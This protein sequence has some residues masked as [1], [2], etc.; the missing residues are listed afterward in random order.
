MTLRVRPFL[1]N[2]DYHWL[3]KV[4]GKPFETPLRFHT[5][6]KFA[7]DAHW[8]YN[9][10]Y[11]EE[12]ERGF[13]FR[14]DLYSPGVYVFDLKPG[15]WAVLYASADGSEAAESAPVAKRDPFLVRRADGRP[16]IV[17]GYPWFTEWGRDTMISLPGLLIAPGKLEPARQIIETWLES[18][19]QGIIPN[20]FPDAGEEPAYNTADATLWMFQAVRM[21]LAAGGDPG[22]VHDVFLP[23]GARDYRLA[24]ARHPARH[25]RGPAGSPAAR[26]RAGPA[27]DLD[28]REGRRPGDYTARRQAGGDQRAVAF[29]AVPD[30]GVGGRRMLGGILPRAA[31][32]SRTVTGTTSRECLYDV[33]TDHGPDA[34]LRPNQVIAVS[35]GDNLLGR[36]QQQQAVM[37]T[38]ERE[39]LTPVGLRTLERGDPEYQGRYEGG[40]AERD[41]A[42]HQGTVWP[43]LLGPFADAYLA[44]FGRTPQTLE[45][46]SGLLRK[47]EEEAAHGPC[48]GSIPEI[49]DGD[50]PHLPRGCPA[51]AW[52]VA[53]AARLKAE[54][55]VPG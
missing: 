20:R 25:R 34:Q 22:F 29:R 31:K 42:Y 18:R 32:F 38:V 35:L 30:G 39:L 51:Q 3:Q 7:E 11:L 45:Y 47:L 8:Y 54:L 28:G 49:Y 50:E 23:G 6:A 16:S 17:A 53:E 27:V 33:L 41:A 14:E 13:D 2:R 19:K 15:E 21:W 10:E 55:G 1:A 4:W 44:A 40:P 9:V 43:W 24:H 5:P 52:S 48:L 12:L 36:V 37:R 46:C 26:G